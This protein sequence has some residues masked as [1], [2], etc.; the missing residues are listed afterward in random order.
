[1]TMVD[2]Y[3]GLACRLGDHGQCAVG[4]PVQPCLCECH[5]FKPV[6]GDVKAGEMLVYC[7]CGSLRSSLHPHGY[8]SENES[9]VKP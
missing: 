3:L 9:D 7:E 1:M 4:P 5:G 8:D 6:C 2:R